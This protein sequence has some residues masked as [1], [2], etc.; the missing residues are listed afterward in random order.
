M[1]SFLEII[2]VKIGIQPK[3]EDNLNDVVGPMDI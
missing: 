1:A 3:T 2:D